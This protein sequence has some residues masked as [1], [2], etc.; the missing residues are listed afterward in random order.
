MPQLQ[1]P[2]VRQ[3]GEQVSCATDSTE[4]H[5]DYQEDPEDC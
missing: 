3:G 2:A 4:T 5:A 1:V